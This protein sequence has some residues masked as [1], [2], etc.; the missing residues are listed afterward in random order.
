M[1]EVFSAIRRSFASAAMALASSSCGARRTSRWVSRTASNLSASGVGGSVSRHV[2]AGSFQAPRGSRHPVS[3]SDFGTCL[4]SKIR[5]GLRVPADLEIHR[6]LGRSLRHRKDGYVGAAF[7]FGIERDATIDFGEQG[8]V[9]ADPDILAGVPLGAALA[10]DNVAA[11]AGF[12]AEQLHAEALTARVAPV[13]RR[14]ASFLVGHG[15]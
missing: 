5:R 3:P 4:W 2:I 7:G 10:H 13:A 11:A 12:A 6:L 8:V 1:R 14:S 15:L 9:L